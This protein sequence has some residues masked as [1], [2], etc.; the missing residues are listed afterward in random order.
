M[1][2]YRIPEIAKK[3]TEYDMIQKHT[4]LPE[5]PE[6]RTRLLYAFLNGDSNLTSSGELFTLVTSLVQ[7]GLDTHDLVSVTNEKKK[8]GFTLQ[9]IESAGRGLFQ[10]TFL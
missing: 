4:N 8:K 3:Y 7:I 9:A 2:S 1:N 5:F 10:F 6:F